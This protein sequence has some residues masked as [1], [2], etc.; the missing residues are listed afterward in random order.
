MLPVRLSRLPAVLAL[1]AAVVHFHPSVALG[2]DDGP[3]ALTTD[4]RPIPVAPEVIA[5]NKAG[6]AIRATRISTPLVIDGQ[7][8]ESVYAQVKSITEFVQQDPHEGAPVSEHTEAWVLYDDHNVYIACRCLDEHPEHMVANEMRRDSTNLRQND[9]F[10]VELDTFHDKRNGFLFYVTPVGGMWDSLTTD[11][12]SNNGDW[13][14]VW[15]AKGRR[16]ANGWI[17]EIAIP[18]K[19]LRYKPGREQVWGINLRRGLRYKNEN[20]YVSPIKPQ[21]GVGGIFHV[22]AAATL[23]GLEAPPSSKNLEIKPATI[24]RLTTDRLAIPAVAN[25]VK[26]DVAVDAKYGLTKSLTADLTYNTDFAQVEADEVQVN[27]T[28]FSLQFPEKRDFFLEGQ[29]MFQFGAVSSTGSPAATGASASGGST[30]APTIFYSR[31]IGL[32]NGTVVPILGGGRVSG[33]AGKWSVGAL[34]MASRADTTAKVPQTD[35]T[36]IR[37][38]RDVLHRST[39]GLMV[40]DRSQSVVAS[41]A[42]TLVGVDGNFSFFQNVYVSGYIAGTSTPTRTSDQGSYRG[43][44]SYGSDRYGFSVDRMAIDRNFNPEIGFVPRQ[45]VRRNFASARFSPRPRRNHLVRRFSYDGGYNYETDNT[46]RLE[47]REVQGDYR[48]EMQNSDVLSVEAFRNYELLRKPLSLASNVKVPAGAYGFSHLRTA[49]AL[50]QQHR[51]S[52]VAAF[53]TGEFYDGT[54]HTFS[55]N[56]RYGFTRQ[57]GVEPNVSLNWVERSGTSAL[58][59]ATGAR[60]TFTVTPRMFV[61][62]LVQ[63][64]SSTHS[65]STNFRFRWE[66]QPGSELFVVYTDG[67][68]TSA[69]L[70][71]PSLQNRGVVIKANRLFR[72]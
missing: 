59:R 46:N 4:G 18:F 47:S 6:V 29:G 7:L 3:A 35:F 27:L 57:L 30:D 13:N 5:S 71:A 51:L 33:R 21:W 62:A 66:Y 49:L 69:V 31:Q 45:N 54:K 20:A 53:D 70:G 48:I 14:T 56:A 24:N 28:R 63:Y 64:A 38:R 2:A 42:N 17:A 16:I 1:V 37:V 68:D 26:A 12:R 43:N 67:H 65:L 60:T 22:S 25:R 44:V 11:E 50:G 41:G 8:D 61:S 72:L 32:S 39:V 19:S 15:E 40:A 34:N 58:I 10:A 9:N 55:L 36:V 23:V 52:G